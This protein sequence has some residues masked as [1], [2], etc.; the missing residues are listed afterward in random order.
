[1][2]GLGRDGVHDVNRFLCSVRFPK[3]RGK[4]TKTVPTEDAWGY[5]SQYLIGVPE[6]QFI[7][8]G[9]PLIMSPGGGVSMSSPHDP[10]TESSSRSS[11]PTNV[12]CNS[13]GTSYDGDAGIIST[14]VPH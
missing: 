2:D 1:M 8:A 14:C 6:K 4:E 7:V 9:V 5:I 3:I 13:G 12:M 10:W 11:P